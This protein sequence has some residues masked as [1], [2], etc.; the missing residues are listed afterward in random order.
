MGACAAWTK[1]LSTKHGQRSL[2][3]RRFRHPRGVPTH[4]LRSGACSLIFSGVAALAR[5]SR[6]FGSFDL[7]VER[8]LRSMGEGIDLS[9]VGGFDLGTRRLYLLLHVCRV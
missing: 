7:L 1:P 2:A 8:N 3:S 4:D 6:R 9:M 5:P